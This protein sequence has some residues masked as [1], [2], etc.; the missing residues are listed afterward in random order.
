VV[1]VLAFGITVAL[2]V[3]VWR[4]MS[5]IRLLTPWNLRRRFR[6]LTLW[7]CLGG[8]LSG[9]LMFWLLS[10]GHRFFWGARPN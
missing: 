8:L 10:I 6:P 1:E 3:Y 4:R 5:P 9:A 2:W 7:D